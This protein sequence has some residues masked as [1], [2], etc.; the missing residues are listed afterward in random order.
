MAFLDIVAQAQTARTIARLAVGLCLTP[1]PCAAADLL[2]APIA[3]RHAPT[4]ADL[5]AAYPANQVGRGSVTLRCV[6]APD[7]ALADCARLGEAAGAFERAARSLIPSFTAAY[8]RGGG[9]GDRVYGDIDFQFDRAAA[10]VELA[11]PQFLQRP[12]ERVE[13]GDFPSGAVKAGLRSGLGVV[14]CDGL[15]DGRLGSCVVVKEA[16]AGF[17]FGDQALARAM[18]LRLNPWQGGR[19]I[20]GA[21]VRLPIF[22]DAPGAAVDPSFTRPAVFH[23]PVG[24]N[25][26]V[27]PQYPLQAY[28]QRIPGEVTLQ[29]VLSLSGALSDCVALQESPMGLHFADTAL[30]MAE[31]REITANPATGSAGQRRDGEIVR[32]AVPFKP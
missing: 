13:T 32:V 5:L 22:I 2:A 15:A 25:T 30:R 3:W 9:P 14:E 17:G 1:G 8:P 12:D 31:R 29:C 19:A 27:I 21:R 7:G 16:P 24:W 6:I 20:E 28:M 23:L 11:Q 10:P 26:G 4:Q 18:K